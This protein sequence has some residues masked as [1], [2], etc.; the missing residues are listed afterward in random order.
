MSFGELIAQAGR[1]RRIV[2][3]KLKSKDGQSLPQSVEFEPYSS[4]EFGGKVSFFCLDVER[5]ACLNVDLASVVDVEIT[6][7]RF[8]PRFPVAF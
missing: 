7:R 1:Q 8:K 6:E 2:R 3:L 4:R 5:F